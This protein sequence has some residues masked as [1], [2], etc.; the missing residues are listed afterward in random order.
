MISTNSVLVAAPIALARQEK[1]QS[2]LEN[3][4][5]FIHALVEVSTGGTPLTPDNLAKEV[6][7]GTGATSDHTPLQNQSVDMIAEGVNRAFTQIRTYLRPMDAEIREGVHRIYTP[8]SAITAVHDN[9]YIRYVEL[10]HPFFDSNFFPT[11]TPDPV[12]D[13]EN[14]EAKTLNQWADRFPELNEEGVAKLLQTASE[15][16]HAQVDLE[17][18]TEIYNECFVRGN[19]GLLFDVNEGV[20]GLGSVRKNASNLTQAYIIASRLNVEEN[21][22]EG[23]NRM[24]LDQYRGYIHQI[25][26]VTTY[27]LQRLRDNNRELAKL[28]LPVLKVDMGD[29]PYEYGTIS[30]DL[31]V[32]LT[33]AAIAELE[34]TDTTLSEVL[35]G[36]AKA[37]YDK[38]GAGSLALPLAD[39]QGYVTIYR[40]YIAMVKSKIISESEARVK[41]VVENAVV[42]FQKKHS[43]LS[44]RLE[45]AEGDLPYRRLYDS[46]KDVA[47]TW[48]AQYKERVVNQNVPVDE[49]LARPQLAIAVARKL[50]MALA[51]DILERSVVSTDMSLEQ[52]RTKLAEAVTEC[53]VRLCLGRYL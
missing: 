50:G 10:D 19:W 21:V 23:V 52:Q 18:A 40:E 2:L 16:L 1:G 51:A 27:A 13:Y 9:L 53:I 20:F 14:F 5:D 28:K 49:F 44:E 8:T 32:G 15:D 36:Y 35:V 6:P 34:S 29:R 4:A 3:T 7:A 30:G 43:E 46:V 33:D 26:S 12:F 48:V 47:D 25:L 45:G 39:V 38:G 41:Q 17:R 24:T 22:L 37:C 42:N 31:T 11:K